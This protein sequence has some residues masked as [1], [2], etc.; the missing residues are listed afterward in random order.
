VPRWWLDGVDDADRL[1]GLQAAS[2]LVGLLVE[3][4]TMVVA[5]CLSCLACRRC[6]V[7]AFGRRGL[8]WDG[9]GPDLGCQSFRLGTCDIV[10]FA[11]CLSAWSCGV[12]TGVVLLKAWP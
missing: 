7:G 3:P 8:L 4:E 5:F 1:V 12:D 2:G 10:I 11:V 9:L 6:R